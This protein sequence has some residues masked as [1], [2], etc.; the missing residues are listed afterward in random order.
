MEYRYESIVH[1][2][3]LPIKIFTHTL[4]HYPYHWHED[5]ELLLI[6]SGTCEMRTSAETTLLK[7]GDLY[8]INRNDIHHTKA[9]S[10][11]EK[12]ELLVLQFDLS[13]FESFYPGAKALHFKIRN[14]EDALVDSRVFDKL[15]QLLAQM[16]VAILERPTTLAMKIEIY[17]MELLILL[18]THFIVPDAPNQKTTSDDPRQ[19]E[20]LK[21]I[22]NHYMDADLSLSQIADAFYMNPQ[23][24][25]R[26]F[27]TKVG[28]PMKKFL[29]QM[30]LNKSLT[31]LQLTDERVLDI[32]L[33]YGFPDAKAYYRVFKEVLSVTPQEYRDQHKIDRKSLQ[34]MDYFSINSSDTHTRLMRYLD[35]SV[36]TSETLPTRSETH[37]IDSSAARPFKSTACRLTTFGYAPHGLRSDF[38]RQLQRL[39]ADIGFEYIRFHGI[40]SD[41]L[42]VCSRH[43]DGTLFFNFNHIDALFDQF[44]SVNI[45]PFIELG[46]MPK[47]L[48]SKSQTLFTYGANISAPHDLGEWCSLI[49]HFIHHLFNRYGREEVETWYFEFWNEP[50][51]EGIFWADSKERFFAFF[52]ATYRCIKAISPRLKLG[53]F[54]TLFI[55]TPGNWLDAF[56]TFAKDKAIKLDFSSFHLYNIDFNLISDVVPLIMAQ[57]QAKDVNSFLENINVEQLIRSSKVTLGDVSFM[58]RRID[59]IIE[60]FKAPEIW[61]TEWNTSTNSR[62]LLRDTC[63]TAPF[64]IKTVL[65]NMEKLDGMGY[66]TFTDIFEELALPQPLF[67]GGFG[68][69]TTNGLRKPS[70]HAFA[71]LSQL[72][73]ERLFQSDGILVTRK[74]EELQILLYHYQHYN[75][76]YA[77]LDFSQMSEISRYSVFGETTQKAIHLSLQGLKGTYILTHQFVTPKSGSVFDAWVAMG[78]PKVITPEAFATLD[79]ASQPGYYQELRLV[80][81]VLELDIKLQPHEIRM[82][83]TRPYYG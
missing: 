79:A 52:E 35:I 61:I 73:N 46:F 53:G 10:T 74:G 59:E 39:S 2:E 65:E 3:N 16:M 36:D 75:D 71:F 48:A 50:E 22:D 41:E 24:L 28:I 81:D 19:L 76:L 31:A 58:S 54:G 40:F 45:K 83:K 62:E 33:K 55:D 25:S 57:N 23:Y 38:N 56:N 44:L 64:I 4:D 27:K 1:Q 17:L 20:I 47:V 11:P 60:K 72:G 21:Y 7:E 43:S 78:S 66:W 13:H 15:R 77:A 37:V 18:T 49:T 69:M 26:Y 34:P 6:L 51:I 63:Y 42:R 14:S 82:I 9:T 32:A 12:T 5:S 80:Q 30:R 68:L 67:H 29:D 70:Y 8:F